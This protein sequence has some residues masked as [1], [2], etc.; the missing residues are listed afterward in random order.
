MK[1][2]ETLTANKE[3]IKRYEHELPRL[4]EKVEYLQVF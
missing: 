2:T 4:Y 1:E 3:N